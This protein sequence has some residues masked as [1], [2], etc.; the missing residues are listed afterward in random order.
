MA[1]ELSPIINDKLRIIFQMPVRDPYFRAKYTNTSP[2]P[3]DGRRP[4]DVNSTARKTVTFEK[5]SNFYAQIISTFDPQL[6]GLKSYS[7]FMKSDDLVNPDKYYGWNFTGPL[8]AKA[9]DSPDPKDNAFWYAKNTTLL[10]YTELWKL[11]EDQI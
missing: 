3:Q 5:I 4:E 11:G 7:Y 9:W 1:C 8:G 10:W 6:N 2:R